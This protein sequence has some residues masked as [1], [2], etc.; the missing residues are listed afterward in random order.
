MSTDSDGRVEAA[1]SEEEM[2]SLEALD[3]KMAS[4]REA[5]ERFDAVKVGSNRIKPMRFVE[6]GPCPFSLLK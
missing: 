5:L 2:A 1:S 4:V 6:H 3:T